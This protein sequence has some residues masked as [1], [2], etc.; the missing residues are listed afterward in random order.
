MDLQPFSRINPCGYPGL[1]VTDLAA[2]G[3][4]TDVVS[5]ADKLTAKLAG[6]L[7]Y[8]SVKQA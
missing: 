3:I 2:L 5:V 4:D 7:G 1:A 8:T 6:I